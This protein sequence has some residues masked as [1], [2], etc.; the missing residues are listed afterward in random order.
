M[1]GDVPLA[2]TEKLAALPTDTALE[3]GCVVMVG[4]VTTAPTTVSVTALLVAEPMLLVATKVYVA[5]SAEV[6]PEMVRIVLVAPE[7]GLEP[8]NHCSVGVAL[9]H[10]GQE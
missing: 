2:T 3:L 1:S 4:A 5:A 10:T 6:A 9:V 8:L 7:M